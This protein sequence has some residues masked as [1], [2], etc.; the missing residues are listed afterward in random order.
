ML[1][2][3]FGTDG[4][5]SIIAEDFTF[6][7][8]AIVTQS[9]ANYLL[10]LNKTNLKIVIGY[11]NRF[12]SEKFAEKVA[13]VLAGNSIKVLVSKSAVPT[14]ATAYMVK[15]RKADGAFMITASHNP[16]YYNGIK[17]IPE[18]AG[19]ANTGITSKIEE[20]LK[21]VDSFQ[22]V[23]INQ[24]QKQGLVEYF[25]AK[26]VY[27]TH[28]DTLVDKNLIK[29]SNLKIVVDYLY[30]A[31]IGY[32]DNYLRD[33][34]QVS[35]L[36]DT[37]NPLF[38][39][40]YP[41]PAEKNLGLLREKVKEI[42]AHIGIA[43]DGDADRFGIIDDQG[44]FYSPNQIFTLLLPYLIE[45]RKANGPV[46]RTVA[47]THQL[48]RIADYYGLPTV[49]TPVG[50]KY[51]AEGFLKDDAIFGAEESGGMSIKGH[52]PEKDGILTSLLVVE[53]LARTKKPLHKLWQE[54]CAKYGELYQERIDLA[55][56]H[57]EKTRL[58]EQVKN[59]DGNKIGSLEIKEVISIDGKKFI[60]D[61][62]LWCLIRPS[63]TEDIVRIYLEASR[64]KDL[65]KL[66]EEI[67]NW[68]EVR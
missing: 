38:D 25:L 51:I 53:M 34:A 65:E 47:T 43:L 23:K 31:G 58:V 64:Q 46:Y 18:Y 45:T 39:N 9:I 62:D 42:K 44:N 12:L 50:F 36:H 1:K 55:L 14:P 15:D 17:F 66:K 30:G 5:R 3:K 11:D 4:W 10:K 56:L 6:S 35:T 33:V 60:F 67:S 20:E 40:L 49:E 48:D 27:F 21:K 32:I 2:I 22:E 7:N 28:L 19:P 68:L 61:N 29:E 16:Y 52:I 37:R 63:G 54:N 57:E 24:A 13:E 41:D 59:F 8:V 26:D